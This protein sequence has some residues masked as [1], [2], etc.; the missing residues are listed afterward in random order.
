MTNEEIKKAWNT[1]K[2]KVAK[3]T[4]LGGVPSYYMNIKQMANRTATMGIYHY[5]LEDWS[6]YINRE[7]KDL[8]KI[9]TYDTWTDEEKARSKKYRDERVACW[10]E[11]TEKYGTQ[12]NYADAIVKAVLESKAFKEFCDKV[13]DVTYTFETDRYNTL[14]VRLHY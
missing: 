1:F 9:M 2:R 6:Y 4:E 8:A 14:F 3:E 11:L 13:G 7:N 10:T 5:D 12:K